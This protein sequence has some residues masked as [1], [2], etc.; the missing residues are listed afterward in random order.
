MGGTLGEAISAA[1]TRT[2]RGGAQA[3]LRVETSV[4]DLEALSE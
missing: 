2:M 1:A 3:G 4:P